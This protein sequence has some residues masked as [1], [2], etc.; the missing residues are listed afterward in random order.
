MAARLPVILRRD[1]SQKRDQ[2]PKL[3]DYFAIE[4]PV[5]RIHDEV[6]PVGKGCE[7]FFAHFF[8]CSELFRPVRRMRSEYLKFAGSPSNL[9]PQMGHAGIARRIVWGVS[10]IS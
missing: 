4:T 8:L 6:Q 3:L 5:R 9:Q 7:F 2:E 10:R 1:L